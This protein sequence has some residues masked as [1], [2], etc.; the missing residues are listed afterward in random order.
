MINNGKKKREF[1]RRRNQLSRQKKNSQT[2]SREAS[3]GTTCELSIGLNL[4]TSNDKTESQIAF[5]VPAKIS[6]TEL[7]GY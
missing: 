5:D 4:D 1:K 2:L 6:T 3:E 7:R